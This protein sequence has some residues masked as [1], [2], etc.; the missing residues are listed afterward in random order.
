LNKEHLVAYLHR[1]AQVAGWPKAGVGT[2]AKISFTIYQSWPQHGTRSDWDH[3]SAL[4]DEAFRK[5]TI[6]GF[7]NS[8]T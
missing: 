3:A 7:S 1:T 5:P 2:R 4:M 8:F 6:A